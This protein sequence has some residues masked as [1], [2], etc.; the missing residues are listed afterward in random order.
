MP[1][2]A[3]TV[4]VGFAHHITQQGNNKQDVFFV[5][6]D[7]MVYLDYLQQNAAKYA[8]E[9]FGYCLMTNH[10]HIAAVP[11]IHNTEHRRQNLK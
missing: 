3:R 7:R 11:R 8:L 6:D 5:D 4:A 10:I 1:R 2:L 9:V